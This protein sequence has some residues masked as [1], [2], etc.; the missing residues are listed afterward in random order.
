M[1]TTLT[2]KGQIALPASAR[3]RLG[4]KPGA[5]F[6]CRVQDGGIMLMP[7]KAKA[8]A[9]RSRF[10]KSKITGQIVSKGAKGAPRVTSEQVRALLADFP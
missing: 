7:A 10:I 1:T 2:R 5:K 6:A 4:V 8:K 9:G 3:K